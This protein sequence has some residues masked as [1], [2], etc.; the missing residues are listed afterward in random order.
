[1]L[2]KPDSLCLSNISDTT[3]VVSDDKSNNNVTDKSSD[4]IAK[5][6]T[7]EL[8]KRLLQN[9][10][11]KVE[12]QI[13]VK[14]KKVLRNRKLRNESSINC[15]KSGSKPVSQDSFLDASDCVRPSFRAKTTCESPFTESSA[16]VSHGI[17]FLTRDK[18]E[19]VNG[20]ENSFSAHLE[21]DRSNGTR[22]YYNGSMDKQCKSDQSVKKP[23]LPS[24]KDTILSRL[25]EDD[26]QDVL[27]I[28]PQ[29]LLDDGTMDFL[30][31]E[32]ERNL[33]LSS[34]NSVQTSDSSEL[35]YTQLQPVAGVDSIE[36]LSKSG[37]ANFDECFERLC[38]ARFDE[39]ENEGRLQIERGV[40]VDSGYH[41]SSD[42]NLRSPDQPGDET[43]GDEKDEDENDAMI[44]VPTS[45]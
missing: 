33:C 5:L 30:L 19:E 4:Y 24:Y 1:M 27:P 6:S 42:G 35:E 44:M 21:C 40:S 31:A 7:A 43:T 2:T 20:F 34:P 10:P 22:S 26:T 25:F 32:A 41:T 9:R 39:V 36:T 45:K 11:K 8:L 13:E 28:I 38:N 14:K 3:R 15:T 29:E 17:S 37:Y 18:T 16:C 12:T 23:E